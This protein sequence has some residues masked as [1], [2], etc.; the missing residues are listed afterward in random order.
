MTI[1]NEPIYILEPYQ[2]AD[3]PTWCL[4]VVV[5][6][7]TQVAPTPYLLST[8]RAQVIALIGG[9]LGPTRVQA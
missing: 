5:D 3:C 7:V 1:I 9:F 8:P 6:G 4:D 2:V